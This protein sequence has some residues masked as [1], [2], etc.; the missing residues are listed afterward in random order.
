[1]N[2]RRASC[3]VFLLWLSVA[4]AA[5]AHGQHVLVHD[6]HGGTWHDAE[7]AFD[8]TDDDMCWAA[9]GSNVLEWTGWAEAGNA[10]AGDEQD[11]F[12]H[13]I[14][15]WTNDGG[16]SEIAWE[17]WFSGRDIAPADPGWAWVDVPGG[18]GYW[19]GHTMA[20][21]MA[22]WREGDGTYANAGEALVDLVAGGYGINLGLTDDWWS[23][24]H[25]VTCWGYT[26]FNSEIVSIHITDSDNGGQPELEHY[27]VEITPGGKVILPDYAGGAYIEDICA[28][29]L[30]PAMWTGADGNWP[31]AGNWKRGAVPG[32][33]TEVLADGGCI[34]IGS[35]AV[36]AGSLAVGAYTAGRLEQTGGAV[37]V[38]GVL[39]VGYDTDAN[40]LYELA[41][42]TLTAEEVNVGYWGRGRYVQTAGQCSV[43]EFFYVDSEWHPVAEIAGGD[44]QAGAV[45]IGEW[46]RGSLIQSGDGNV[47]AVELYLGYDMDSLGRYEL[48]G[49]G[50]DVRNACVGYLGEGQMLQTGGR[51]TVTG[52]LEIDSDAGADCDLRGGRLDAN[53]V[54][55]GT[56]SAGRLAVSG[57][58]HVTAEII[59]VGGGEGRGEIEITGG[60][61][62]ADGIVLGIDT[63]SAGELTL[64]G[65]TLAVRTLARGDGGMG[66]AV[67]GGRLEA[68]TLRFDLGQVGGEL[69]PLEPGGSV[70]VRGDYRLV[71]GAIALGIGGCDPCEP[72][73]FDDEQVRVDGNA[74]LAGELALHWLAPDQPGYAPF[75]RTVDVL[76]CGGEATGQLQPAGQLKAYVETI[77]FMVLADGRQSVRVTL[78]DLLAGDADLDGTVGPGDLDALA[79][80]LGTPGATWL[81]GDVD[82]SGTADAA[83]YA[84]IK[85]RFGSTLANPIPEPGTLAMLSLALPA[86]LRRRLRRV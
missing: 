63:M 71:G 36:E 77:A 27:A 59:G 75:G 53:E 20:D 30:A 47:Q 78:R 70:S 8:G 12:Q 25:A 68:E 15:H 13:Y 45:S 55:I 41:G 18:G 40:G 81:D 64:S 69:G 22:C 58:A 37:A 2:S 1:M 3:G 10:P 82:G 67:T 86:L 84:C 79:A 6:L 62:E 61:L 51:W 42:G 44:L 85:R 50:L 23:W 56:Y 32:A 72:G 33:G 21:Y 26:I 38:G 14:D 17:W 54:M 11:V 74:S 4:W 76:V 57:T 48:R 60:R 80:G 24:S 31:V 46:T 29:K 16:D 7:K 43:S 73:G 9:A 19:P 5:T 49:G 66:V 52:T 35:G 28:L 39:Y 34:R 83:D 65:G